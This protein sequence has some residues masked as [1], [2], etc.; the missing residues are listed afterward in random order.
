MARSRRDRAARRRAEKAKLNAAARE[1]GVEAV[2]EDAKTRPRNARH[3]RPARSC[4]CTAAR[5]RPSRQSRWSLCPRLPLLEYRASSADQ[6]L[7]SQHARQAEEIRCAGSRRAVDDRGSGAVRASSGG[8]RSALRRSHPRLRCATLP[9][10][11]G[12]RNGQPEY[13]ML[14]GSCGSRCRCCPCTTAR[15]SSPKANA[16]AA[17]APPAIRPHSSAYSHRPLFEIGQRCACLTVAPHLAARVAYAPGSTSPTALRHG[18]A[19]SRAC[20]LLVHRRRQDGRGDLEG[21]RSGRHRLRRVLTAFW[22]QW[23]AWP[24]AFEHGRSP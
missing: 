23:Q 24:A 15:F 16:A 4:S 3:C 1:R 18:A 22:G 9:P 2:T 21:Y 20:R 8:A 13:A 11:R 17:A 7:R 19:T 5:S 10:Q 12:V 6:P 14:W